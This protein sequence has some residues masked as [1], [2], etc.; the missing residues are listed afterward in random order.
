MKDFL[1]D[2]DNLLKGPYLS[3]ADAAP[4]VPEGTF[5]SV[6][7][8]EAQ[9]MVAQAWRL[10]R[11]IVPSGRND[12]FIV[13]DAHQRIYS[14]HRVVLGRCGI[15]ICGRA[16]KL[17][18]N[19]R[20]TEETRRWASRLLDRCSIDDLDGGADNN[21]GVRSVAH[22]PEPRLR[23]FQSRDEQA[24]LNSCCQCHTMTS[25]QWLHGPSHAVDMNSGG[26]VRSLPFE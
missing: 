22:G 23:L 17:R 20:T 15:D 19:Y 14:R 24:A 2:S 7:V 1:D 9:D 16:R 26:H 18:L 5:T 12:L 25:G 4:S 3:G 11:S 6:V 13:G 8:D 21:R 10:I